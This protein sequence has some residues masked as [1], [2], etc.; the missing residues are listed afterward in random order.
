MLCLPPIVLLLLYSNDWSKF[1]PKTNALWLHY[2]VNKVSL[3]GRHKH[4]T[5]KQMQLRLR[6][7][8]NK[9]TSYD[10]AKDIFL[11]LFATSAKKSS[12]KA[13]SEKQKPK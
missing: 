8:L 7:Y 3:K 5:R 11:S 10:S 2:I 6:P 12:G 1:A 13:K 4:V 9:F